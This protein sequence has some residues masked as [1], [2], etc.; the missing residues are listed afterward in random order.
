MIRYAHVAPSCI[1]CGQCQEHCPMDIPN[2]LFMHAMQTETQELFGFG[3]P[4]YDMILPVLAY[5]KDKKQ[6]IR[7]P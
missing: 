6:R 1:N 4:G 3:K 5:S 7:L 2:T